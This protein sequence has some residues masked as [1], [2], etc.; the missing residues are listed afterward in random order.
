MVAAG[1]GSPGWLEN[2]GSGGGLIGTSGVNERAGRYA[3]QTSGGAAGVGTI[4]SGTAGSFGRGG[5]GAG[6]NGAAGGGGGYYGGG[7]GGYTNEVDHGSGGGGSSFI[8]GY[9]GC[10]AI[11]STGAHTG[12][13]NHY[14]GYIFTDMQM[15]DGNTQMSSPSGAIE[16]GHSGNG[17]ARITYL[18]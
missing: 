16:T 8:S 4:A 13:P 3:T 2:G 7:G 10:N 11:N 1:A 12:Q 9:T 5:A 17:Y 14:S 6:N 18:P 15:I